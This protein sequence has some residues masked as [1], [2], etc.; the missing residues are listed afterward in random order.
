MTFSTPFFRFFLFSLIVVTVPLSAALL[1]G[2][3]ADPDHIKQLRETGSCERCELRDADLGGVNAELG[4]LQNADL[5]GA[6]LYKAKL[7][8]AD[9]SG[10]LLVLADLT[11]ANLRLARGANLSGAVTDERTICPDGTSGPCQ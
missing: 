6:N 7:Q 4:N 10:A 5:R 8:G 1:A 2:S 11:G 3:A 9:L